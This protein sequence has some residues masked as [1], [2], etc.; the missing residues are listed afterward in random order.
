MFQYILLMAVGNTT[1]N[2]A[3]IYLGCSVDTTKQLIDNEFHH[4]D[5]RTH[6]LFAGKVIYNK[7][8]PQY[9]T[10]LFFKQKSNIKKSTKKLEA[11]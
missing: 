3:Q 4:C 8:P 1:K 5:K 9:H 2:G 10:S 11:I 7:S 6:F